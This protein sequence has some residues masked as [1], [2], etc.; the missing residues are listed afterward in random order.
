MVRMR[1]KFAAAALTAV[2][3]LGLTPLPAM[4]ELANETAALEWV[5]DENAT[6]IDAIP[7]DQDGLAEENTSLWDGPNETLLGSEDL[8][9]VADAHDAPTID[10]DTA[11]VE[12]QSLTTQATL[13]TQEEAVAFAL[14]LEGQ[15]LDVLPDGSLDCIDVACTYYEYLIGYWLYGNGCDYALGNRPDTWARV[16]SDP[17]PG[18]VATWSTGTWGHVAVVVGVQGNTITV[19]EQDTNKNVPCYRATYDAR[20]PS[21]YLRPDFLPPDRDPEGKLELCEGGA[22]AVRISGWAKDPNSL[23]KPVS[24]EVYVGGKMGSRSATHHTVD[25]SGKALVADAQRDDLGGTWGFDYTLPVETIGKYRVYVYAVDN[26]TKTTVLLGDAPKSTWVVDKVDISKCGVKLKKQYEYT[27]KAIKPKPTVTFG[28]TTLKRGTDYTLS[29]KNNVKRG[30]AT[31]TI[32]GKGNYKGSKKVTFKIKGGKYTV[33]FAAN[34]GTGTMAAQ[35]LTYDKKTA[36]SKN[37]F[38]RDGYKFVGWNTKKDGSGKKY[39][40]K[41]KVKSLAKVGKKVTL[42]AQ[43]RQTR[44]G[45]WATGSNADARSLYDLY[46]PVLKRAQAGTGEFAENYKRCGSSWSGGYEPLWYAVFD[47]DRD[48]TPELLVHNG[49]FESSRRV[50][51]FTVSKGKVVHVGAIGAGHSLF[52]ANS[53]G[54]LFRVYR[55]SS[56]IET[57][58]ITYVNGALAYDT[59]A[60]YESSDG[61]FATSAI[62]DYSLLRSRAVMGGSVALVVNV[63][64]AAKVA[65]TGKAVKPKVTVTCLGRTLKAGTDYTVSFTNASGAKAT[66]KAKGTYRAVVTGKKGFDGS[67]AKAFEVVDNTYTVRFSANGGKG[68]TKAQII[69]RGKRVAL[70]A[71]A[72]KRSGYN[73]A[74]WNTKKDGTGTWYQNKA[75]VKD[76]GKLG[77]K[78]TLYAQWQDKAANTKARAA[79]DEVIKQINATIDRYGLQGT[80]RTFADV[81][82]DSTVEM[83]TETKPSVGSGRTYRVY[84]YA[85]GKAFLLLEVGGY[86]WSSLK[87]YRSAGSLVVYKSGHGHEGYEY[88]RLDG[89]SYA[90]VAMSGRMS[91]A[92]GSLEDG[93]WNYYVDGSSTTFSETV[94]KAEFNKAISDL[95]TGACVEVTNQN[96]EWVPKA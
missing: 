29:Y 92:G 35:T 22:H 40:N 7:D 9:Q 54:E 21:S 56:F 36:L 74:A 82:G 61:A 42:Y 4:A 46:L 86:G 31:V 10:D 53:N 5:A 63:S 15:S 24:L 78:V 95:E 59:V 27:G 73:F 60:S 67:V 83:L 32:K 12:P 45:V 76:L 11:V 19:V 88:Y 1:D 16:Y 77:A 34:G 65:Y 58:R 70:R 41:A 52:G 69:R 30:T 14:S 80:Y 38:V 26:E 51:V 28:A 47:I 8:P 84:T 23:N 44:D 37:A 96:W 18:D 13:H 20:N 71:N 49:T 39:K 89:G 57:V 25:A 94:S 62:T 33:R 85:N 6:A 64:V 87:F 66:P 72:F 81:Y 75:K 50:D 3:M 2:M 17:Q 43:W 93:S 79:Y 48:G 55:K 68:S 91:K 90:Y